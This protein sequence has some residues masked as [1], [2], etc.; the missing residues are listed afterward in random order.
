MRIHA[1][2]EKGIDGEKANSV[3]RVGRQVRKERK[4]VGGCFCKGRR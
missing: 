4:K 1:K 2:K 3:G